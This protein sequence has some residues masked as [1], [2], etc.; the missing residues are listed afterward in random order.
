MQDMRPSLENPE[1]AFKYDATA[2]LLSSF[3]AARTRRGVLKGALAGTA[4]VAAAAAGVGLMN[5]IPA[6]AAEKDGVKLGQCLDNP[7]T[8]FSVARTAEMLAITFYNHGIANASALG[9]N[10][11]DKFNLEALRTEEQIHLEFFIAQ[12]GEALASTFSFPHGAATFTNLGFFIAA[13]QQLEGVFDSAF[14]AAVKEFADLR[15]PTTA[16][17]AAQIALVEGQHYTIGRQIA[18]EHGLR[19]FEPLAP[20]AFAPVLV[21]SVSNAVEV[22]KNAGYLS[23]T[24][25]NSFGFVAAP[26]RGFGVTFTAPFAESCS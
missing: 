11:T 23:P 20:W 8:I 10:A 16:Q 19:G 2:K 21:K 5:I 18:S 12:G 25:G 9:L 4:G 3:T 6:L 26:D 15:M 13:Q 17:I 1:E 7:V 22:A 14:L 24:P